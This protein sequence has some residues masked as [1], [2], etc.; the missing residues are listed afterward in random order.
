MFSTCFQVLK[1]FINK[2]DDNDELTGY[3]KVF[4]FLFLLFLSDKYISDYQTHFNL[5]ENS[6]VDMIICF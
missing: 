1:I 3:R 5:K 4:A 2:S 6:H